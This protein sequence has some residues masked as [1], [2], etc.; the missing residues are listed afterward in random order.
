MYILYVFGV[1]MTRHSIVVVYRVHLFIL[2]FNDF[3]LYAVFRFVDIGVI[4]VHHC[5]KFLFIALSDLI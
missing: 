5:F 3:R 1:K 2:V 4:V